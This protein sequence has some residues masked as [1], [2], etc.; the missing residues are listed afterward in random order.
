MDEG[1]EKK[2]ESLVQR[3]E[4]AEKE[5]EEKPFLKVR[6]ILNIIFM[7]GA[8]AGVLIY[9]LSDQTTGTYIILVAMVFKMVEAS[10]RMFH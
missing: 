9:F 2:E 3:K 5:R 10:L 6:N 8:L 4:R 7:L 1:L